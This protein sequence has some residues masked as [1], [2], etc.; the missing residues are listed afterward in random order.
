MGDTD[1]ARKV[2]KVRKADPAA[3]DAVEQAASDGPEE[4]SLA[5]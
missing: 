5:R 3:A 2:D 4:L 1:A